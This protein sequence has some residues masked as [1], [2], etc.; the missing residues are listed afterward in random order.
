[1][2]NLGIAKGNAERLRSVFNTALQIHAFIALV[3]II[4]GE[5]IGLWFLLEKLV[6]PEERIT[7]AIWVYQCSIIACVVNIM[8]V[9]YN[10][11]IIA[12]DKMSAVAYISILDVTLR[13]VIVY[14]LVISPID[15]LIAYAILTLLVQLLIRYVYTRYCNK[16][17][18]E[19]FV[20][21][22]I[23]K[24]LFKEMLSFA[25]WSFWGNLVFILGTVGK[26]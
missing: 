25:G 14:L 3:I 20:E 5:T 22:K 10:A 15:K 6:I 23:N 7:A 12:H 19:S 4:L 16:H 2:R 1:M 18:Q 9:P 24:A 8:S 13:L 11:D 26:C 17:F 21:W